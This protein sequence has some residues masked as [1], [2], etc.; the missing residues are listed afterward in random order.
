MNYGYEGEVF[1]LLEVKSRKPLE[2]GKK[3]RL[4]ALAKW[5]VCE[6]VCIPER[7]TLSLE[8]EAS[9]A[10]SK[11]PTL[12]KAR[13]DS[14]RKQIPTLSS[15]WGTSAKIESGKLLLDFKLKENEKSASLN[16]APLRRAEF[17]PDAETPLSH[18]ARQTFERQAGGY[19]LTLELDPNAPA[20]SQVSGVL[21][22]SPHFGSSQERAIEISTNVV[23]VSAPLTTRT[24]RAEPLSTVTEVAKMVIFAFLGGLILNLMPCV[25]P[26]L[27]IKALGV[28][29]AKSHS[30]ASSFTQFSLPFLSGVLA[31]F[32]GLATLLNAFRSAGAQLG[33]GFQ[34]QSPGFVAALIMLFFVI[35]LNLLGVFEVTMPGSGPRLRRAP[36]PLQNFF[37]GVLA[38]IV[39]SPCTAPFMASALG[40]ALSQSGIVS[41]LIFSSLGL[42]FAL[43][44]V[45]LISFPATLRRLP[46]PGPWMVAMKEI[47]S[48]PILITVVW[49]LWVF[50]LQTDV[51]SLTRVLAALLL[52]AIA[53]FIYG[54]YAWSAKPQAR[55]NLLLVSGLILSLAIAWTYQAAT[56]K[57]ILAPADSDRTF[58]DRHGL[59]WHRFSPAIVERLRSEGRPVFVDFTAAWCITCQFNERAV[60]SSSEV[61]DRIK[62]KRIA[63]VQGDWTTNDPVI[64]AEL[65]RHGRSGVPLYL[66]YTPGVSEP[67]ILPQILAPALVL[68]EFE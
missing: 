55:A 36:G 64:T 42:G 28:L 30:R 49:L 59:E 11:R 17:F 60:F 43:P 57:E 25:F 8:L 63:L 38:V 20:F 18:P 22:A 41:L 66:Y 19:R 14:T 68:R 27:S 23:G 4:E 3:I 26:I 29:Q 10:R 6:K 2:E 12:W 39:A 58:V 37:E 7:A 33:W 44:L 61:R 46:K 62:E 47:F 34:L 53:A 24:S 13:F 16:S 65:L 35:A 45:V 5:L 21:V 48:I 9:A 56:S 54:K 40:Y 67:R 31:T 50:G 52:V 1:L 51:H 32:L 15:R